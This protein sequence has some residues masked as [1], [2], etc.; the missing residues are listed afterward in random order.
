[1]N[2]KY[3]RNTDRQRQQRRGKGGFSGVVKL[4]HVPPFSP[5]PSWQL[6]T[7]EQCFT[8]SNGCAAEYGE[9]VADNE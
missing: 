3:G 6:K 2:H 9:F 1:M 4:H 7:G 5:R 8:G